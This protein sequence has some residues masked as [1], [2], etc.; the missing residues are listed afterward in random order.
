MR[1]LFR[2]ISFYVGSTD[3]LLWISCLGV[4]ALSVVLLLGL[5][6]SGLVTSRQVAV[7]G[8]ASM[9]GVTA[10]LILSRIDYRWLAS[11]YR[12]YVP[13]ALFLIILT[14]FFGIQRMEGVDDRAW[15]MLP[16]IKLTFQPAELLKIAFILFFARE[17]ERTPAINAPLNLM[18][19]C[20]IGALPT[21]MVML[22]GDDGTALIFV[23]IFAAMLF[24]AGLH[25]KYM[26]AA[27]V[28]VALAAP[29][30]WNYYFNYEQ[31]MRILCAYDHTIDPL[32]IGWQQYTSRLSIGSG[33]VWGVGV[34]ADSHYYVPEIHND[35]IFAFVGQAL[36][37]A[38]AV[39]VLALFV[40]ICA[41]LLISAR[42]AK[43]ALGRSI[44]VGVFAMIAAQ[45][46]INIG[47]NLS[48]LPVVG[49]TLPL[50]SA[51]GT[52]VSVTYLAIGLALSVYMGT[53]EGAFLER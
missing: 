36:G 22:Q 42:R 24:G 7:Q 2:Y 18:R 49:I 3:R 33:Q 19:L 9:L 1:R 51:G 10:A 6:H 41:R 16:F 8:L 52:S 15:L 11:L 40:I 21:V 31:K 53:R 25:I 46:C 23:F 28:V 39:G 26:A 30:A 44:C 29:V 12:L 13:V 4:S 37:F 47:M 20:L 35:F 48:L 45:V 27:V 32:G 43:D 34:F 38:G 17:L 50:L 5:R 14:Y